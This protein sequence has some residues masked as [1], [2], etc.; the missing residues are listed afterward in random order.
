MRI[1]FLDLGPV[2][3][4]IRPQ[5]DAAI[6][7]V[8]DSDSYVLGRELASFEA[9][10]AAFCGTAHC[11]GVASG[12]DALHLVLRAYGVGPGDE[13]IVPAHTFVAT[14]LAVT[15]CGA[16]PVA[17]D[18]A[19][20][21]GTISPLSVAAAV[22]PRTRAVVAVDL[23]G[24]PANFE[25]IRLIALDHGLIVVEDAA[26]AHGALYRDERAGSLGDAAAF[27]FYPG[28]NLGALGDGGAIT[29]NDARIAETVR[30]LRNYGGVAKYEHATIGFNSRLDD[31]QAA[32]LSVK[33]TRLESWNERRG[34]VARVYLEKLA[35]VGVD[36]IAADPAARTAWHLFPIRHAR[37][38]ELG[39]A[40][41]RRGIQTGIHY[42]RAVHH[43]GAYVGT[44][45]LESHPVAEDFAVRELS[46]PMGPHM[47]VE[48]A[49]EAADAVAD[50]LRRF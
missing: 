21:D 46:L 25:A 37:R 30:G 8:L 23:Y 42:P 50:A 17:V 6:A 44:H 12:L 24:H 43:T 2:H 20:S 45:G 38:D 10:F 47:T 32:V 33:L 3:A 28:K 48:M 35:D 5:L 11:V 22:T 29:T 9:E 16:R 40:L 34:A 13:V 18:V 15:Y 39:E 19:A 27:S 26:Q 4:E 41:A 36:L 7:R 14:W 49:H 1:P 31:L